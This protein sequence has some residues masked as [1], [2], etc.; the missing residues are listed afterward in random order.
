MKLLHTLFF[1]DTLYFVLFINKHC[2][3]YFN[4]NENKSKGYHVN[5]LVTFI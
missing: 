4:F 2:W 1:V 3:K 5:V